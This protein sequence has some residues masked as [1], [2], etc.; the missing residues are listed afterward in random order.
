MARR[1]R[2]ERREVEPDLRY[3]NLHVAMVCEPLDERRE[4]ELG[5]SP[6]VSE[7]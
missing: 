5:T 4:K 6:F 3:N 2:A 7:F 1:Y